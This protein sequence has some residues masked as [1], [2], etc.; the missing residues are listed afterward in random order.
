MAAFQEAYETMLFDGMPRCMARSALI[1]MKD[2][3]WPRVL[4]KK[5]PA[6]LSLGVR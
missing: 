1:Q 6:S 3:A 5:W 2:V 4:Q